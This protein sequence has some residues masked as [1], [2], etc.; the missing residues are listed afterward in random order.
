M[1][2]TDHKVG[3]FDALKWVLQI[4]PEDKQSVKLKDK[5]TNQLSGDKK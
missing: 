2:W 3:Y 1:T 5:T 4:P